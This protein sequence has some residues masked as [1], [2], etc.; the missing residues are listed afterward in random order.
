MIDARNIHLDAER[1]GHTPGKR[2][3]YAPHVAH[4]VISPKPG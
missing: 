4:K 3:L 2:T 1:A